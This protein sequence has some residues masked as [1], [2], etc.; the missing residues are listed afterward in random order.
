MGKKTQRISKR[1]LQK[2]KAGGKKLK[3][4]QDTNKKSIFSKIYNELEETPLSWCER[5]IIDTDEARKKIL[6]VIKVCNK[7]ITLINEVEK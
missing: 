3:Y 4:I 5:R 7:L 6:K 1:V 2:K